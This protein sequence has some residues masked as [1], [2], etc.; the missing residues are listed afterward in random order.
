MYQEERAMIGE[1]Y[2][3]VTPW[4]IGQ[5]TMKAKNTLTVTDYGTGAASNY[6]QFTNGRLPGYKFTTGTWLVK[7][8]TEPIA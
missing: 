7:R 8:N 5:C 6:V 1:C 3:V 2:R 4:K